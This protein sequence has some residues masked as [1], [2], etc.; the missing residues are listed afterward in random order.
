M[1]KMLIAAIATALVAVTS[2][3]AYAEKL[4]NCKV[5]VNTADV[6]QLVEC[7]DGVGEAIA[8]A[9]IKFR[10]DKQK[11][12]PEFHFSKLDDLDS[13]PRFGK[14]RQK[15]NKGRICFTDKCLKGKGEPEPETKQ[16]EG[17]S[18]ER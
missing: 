13:V 10:E 2:H 7:L 3:T 1:N 11:E 6:E 16:E 12:N 17:E 15:A 8:K 9:I 14:K 5:N 18:H 4:E